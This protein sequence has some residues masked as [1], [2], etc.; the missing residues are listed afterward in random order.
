MNY[1]WIGKPLRKKTDPKNRKKTV[2]TKVKLPHMN[3]K[4]LAR[5]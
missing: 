3:K 2:K 5:K 1:D 4:P